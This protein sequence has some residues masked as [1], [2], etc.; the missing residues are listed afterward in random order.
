MMISSKTIIEEL[1]STGKS[2]SM[3]YYTKNGN[4]IIKTISKI[5]YEYMKKILPDYFN[6]MI[7]NKNSLLPK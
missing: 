7:N 4:F 2:G 6:Y 1:C 5:E 3:F